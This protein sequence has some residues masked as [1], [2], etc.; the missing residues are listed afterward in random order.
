MIV[1]A[2]VKSVVVLNV[3]RFHAVS[4]SVLL[5]S[6][7]YPSRQLPLISGF[8]DFVCPCSKR[9]MIWAM[10]TIL[11]PTWPKSAIHS[12]LIYCIFILYNHE[13]RHRHWSVNTCI[14]R[15]LLSWVGAHIVH[16]SYKENEVKVSQLWNVLPA[17][18]CRSIW[19]PRFLVLREYFNVCLVSVLCFR[20]LDE[21]TCCCRRYTVQHCLHSWD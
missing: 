8:C 2:V 21:F 9:N 18:V 5:Y 7:H 4:D 17:W 15:F 16:W 13:N 12:E 3:Q 1:V 19:L 10:N 20:I 11:Q 14:P 6:R